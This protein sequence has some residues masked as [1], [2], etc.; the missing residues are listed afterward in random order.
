MRKILILVLLLSLA[1]TG[2]FAQNVAAATVRLLKTEPISSSELIANIA[3]AERQ[4]GQA[5]LQ[6]QKKQI[7]EE[8]INTM[9]LVQEA[10]GDKTIVVT[11]DEVS[12]NSMR[13]LSQQLQMAGGLAPGAIITDR[14]TYLQ[15]ASQTNLNI[16]DF[17]A[18]VRKQT[19]AEKLIMTRGADK[20]NS[21]GSATDS[22]LSEIYQ[23]HVQEFVMSDSVWFNHIFFDI[24]GLSPELVRSK[25]DKAKDV[26]RTLMNTSV[27]FGELVV[28]ES[29]DETSKGTGGLTGPIMKGEPISQQVFGQEFLNTVFSLDVGDVSEPLLSGRGYHIVEITRKEPARLLTQ[30]EPEVRQYL[31]SLAK[32]DKYQMTFEEVRDDLL[33]DLRDRATVRYIGEYAN[34]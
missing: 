23:E 25:A 9:L 5:M 14:A 26:Y 27:T 3:E 6:E 7:L 30:D 4:Y 17:E 16:N 34:W 28:Q 8:M 19:L 15:I 29:E 32:A 2:L 13:L 10:E 21:I 20:F 22:E 24:Q 1:T 31:D 12:Q 18:M 33:V 11:G